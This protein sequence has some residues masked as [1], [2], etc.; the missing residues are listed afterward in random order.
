MAQKL[1]IASTGNAHTL[2]H[3]N[4][5]FDAKEYNRE[6]VKRFS[7]I[8][9]VAA[10][11]STGL[12]VDDQGRWSG[13]II[14]ILREVARRL[15]GI[16][17]I[18]IIPVATV[19]DGNDLLL[20]GQVSLNVTP[21]AISEVLLR[22]FAA[23]AISTQ[24]LT[25]GL[26][27]SNTTATSVACGPATLSGRLVGALI[28]Q[29]IEDFA[30]EFII[31]NAIPNNNAVILVNTLAQRNLLIAL[32]VN[33]NDIV[34]LD[35]N[36]LT[37]AQIRENIISI[38]VVRGIPICN[39]AFLGSLPL[40]NSVCFNEINLNASSLRVVLLDLSI[41]TGTVLGWTA[42]KYAP[43]FLYSLQAA[44]DSWIIEDGVAIIVPKVTCTVTGP[45]PLV[46]SPSSPALS[47]GVL[48]CGKD[49]SHIN[50]HERKYVAVPYPTTQC[51]LDA[52][53]PFFSTCRRYIPDYA[54]HELFIRELSTQQHSIAIVREGD[55]GDSLY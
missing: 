15:P 10:A 31:F 2:T 28:P 42:S 8:L 26:I 33:L 24:P 4:S 11:P 47:C 44:L 5:G 34:V 53:P 19:E 40:T 52:P 22:D 14:T 41:T 50:Y 39:V 30:R 54:I 45:P 37:P 35:T 1:S 18:Q 13:A 55:C 43:K 46:T 23:I 17:A 16:T 6:L 48:G 20:T 49:N 12:V 38:A 21:Q 51:F 25:S 9:R 32:S 7:S 29:N 36:L 27:L 3:K